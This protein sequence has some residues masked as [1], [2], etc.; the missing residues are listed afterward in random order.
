MNE[1]ST[2]ALIRW[3]I[4]GWTMA[5]SFI[6]LVFLDYLSAN[7]TSM[8]RFLNGF[9]SQSSG[10]QALAIGFLFTAAG[11]PVGYVIYQVYY[12]LRWNSP[13]SSGGLWPPLIHGRLTEIQEVIGSIEAHLL[14]AGEHWRRE[15][16]ESASHRRRWHFISQL[17]NDALISADKEGRILERHR[18]IVDILNSLG[19]SHLGFLAG[20]LLYL[21][22]KWKLTQAQL[23]WVVVAAGFLFLVVLALASEVSLNAH[24][25]VLN[26]ALK[27][28]AEVLL[29]Y[30]LALFVLLNPKLPSMIPP[31]V[32][33]P[34][35]LIAFLVWGYIV[36]EDRKCP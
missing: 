23:W 24:L 4:P 14:S 6:S 15:F 22:I 29:A 20:F 31:W 17:V 36:K 7:D 34:G 3:G 27:H 32:L 8:Y 12:Y 30:C 19:A 28:P 35:F 21:L 9:L 13:Y 33:Y 26:K 18:T 5:I 1:K 11:V 25:I 16:L 10:M 2:F